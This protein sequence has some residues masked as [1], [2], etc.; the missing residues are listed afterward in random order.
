MTD[1]FE[2]PLTIEE[3][4]RFQETGWVLKR[5]LFLKRESELLVRWADEVALLPRLPGRQMVYFETSLLDSESRIVQRIENF[6]P[7]HA[8][9]ERMSREGKLVKAVEQLFGENVV[10][11]KDKI[12]YKLSGGGGYELHQDQQAGWSRYAP[13]FVNA[14]VAI[15]ESTLENGCLEIANMP[16]VRNMLAPERSVLSE[17]DLSPYGLI[18]C[19][20]CPEDVLFFDSFVPHSS[21]PNLTNRP[22]R[23]LYL[24]FNRQ[25]DGDHRGSYF[26]EKRISFPPGCRA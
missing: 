3:V 9:S 22:R 8:A 15:D 4:L 12:N 25:S 1:S 11:F 5:D 2:A 18:P 10:L 24:T 23:T 14:L 19:P 16:R 26:V 20:T 17:D 6:C 7:H 13:L 21:K